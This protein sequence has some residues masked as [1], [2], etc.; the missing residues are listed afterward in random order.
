MTSA[1]D[2]LARLSP[3][4]RARIE[5]SRRALGS[6]SLQQRSRGHARA[7]ARFAKPRA[8]A[9]SW[10]IGGLAVAAALVLALRGWLRPALPPPLS[11]TVEGGVAA[12]DGALRGGAGGDRH[13]TV[14]FSD[15]TQ[16]ELGAGA[17]AHV[18]SLTEH[19]A[20]ISVDEGEVRAR[21]VHWEGAR[22]LFDAGPFVVTVT[23]TA[24]SLSWTP[25]EE[26]VDLRLENGSV[27]VGGPILDRPISLRSGKWLTLRLR[28]RE[29]LIRD[30]TTAEGAPG[31]AASSATASAP[32]VPG[33]AP[34]AP[35]DGPATS[36]PPAPDAAPPSARKRD[37]A[38]SV[39]AGKFEHV[40]DEAERW[41]LDACLA[42]ASSDELA[43]LADAARYTNK[44]GIAKRALLAQRQRFAGSSRAAEAA[45]LL[46]RLAESQEG[47]AA[48][49]SWFDRTLAEAPSGPYAPEALGRKMVL[50][51]K[52]SGRGAATKVAREYLLRFPRGTYAR[53]AGA[54]LQAP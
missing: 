8:S 26:R 44:G 14:K 4:V 37:W 53:A 16:V 29:I 54:L 5:L 17:R 38:A 12:E 27:E 11:F 20:T 18:A 35:E 21:V 3:A 39:A 22:W 15:G 25:D 1:E 48:A 33:S 30:I 24:F 7:L 40:V 31:A 50:V 34:P 36:A 42:G 43:S 45:F 19:G 10:A 9:P 32:E 41:G 52:T 51:E 46:G 13:P 23:G 2:D 28:Q 47:A 49:V 6:M